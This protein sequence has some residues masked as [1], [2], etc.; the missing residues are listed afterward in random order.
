MFYNKVSF[1]FLLILL[2]SKNQ[3]K[4]GNGSERNHGMID[5]MSTI[6]PEI[7]LTAECLHPCKYRIRDTEKD[8]VKIVKLQEV[9][10]HHQ[11]VTYKGKPEAR[12]KENMNSCPEEGASYL[13]R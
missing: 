4:L 2:V 6:R 13:A 9:H 8:G 7:V 10:I 12:D 3:E 5:S 1:C 11:F